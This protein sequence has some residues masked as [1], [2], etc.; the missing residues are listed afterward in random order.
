MVR[1]GST[2]IIH[3][4]NHLRTLDKKYIIQDP[5]NSDRY[6]ESGCVIPNFYRP[7]RSASPL[8]VESMR[9][10]LIYYRKKSSSSRYFTQKDSCNVTVSRVRLY[11][12]K[13]LS[14]FTQ[15]ISLKSR[16]HESAVLIYYRK[17]SSSSRH[18]THKFRYN[19]TVSRVRLYNS[20]F[21]SS[22]TQYISLKSREHESGSD[23]LSKKVIILKIFHTQILLQRAI[24]H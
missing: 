22:F 19:V 18:S 17:R 14:S 2:I 5:N 10:V 9:A 1:S 4:C 6:H 15:Y 8:K 7:S 24:K 16:E 23:L 20:K 12:S 11:N 13:F 21:L 3:M